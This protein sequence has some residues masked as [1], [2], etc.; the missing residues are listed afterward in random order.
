MKKILLAFGLITGIAG[1][2]QVY[3]TVAIFNGTI[4]DIDVFYGELFIVGD[5]S[6]YYGWGTTATQKVARYSNGVL[7]THPSFFSNSSFTCL[8]EY[9]G[10]LYAGGDFSVSG[11]Y[12]AL[13]WNG[14]GGWTA[15]DAEYI[16]LNCMQTYNGKL[17]AGEISSGYI[18]EKDGAGAFDSIFAVEHNNSWQ[19]L[20]GMGIYDGDLVMVGKFNTSSAGGASNYI[21]GY[22]GTNFFDYGSGLN[23]EAL[24]V[25]EYHGNMYVGGR[26]TN[27]S[28]ANAIG[29]AIWDGSTWSDVDGS[30]S[31]TGEIHDM[32]VYNNKLWVCGNFEQIGGQWAYDLAY[33]DTQ[34]WH[35]VSFP[36][37]HGTAKNLTVYNDKFYISAD[38][39]VDSSFLYSYSEP[40]GFDELEQLQL[41]VYPNPAQDEL[42]IETAIG[43]TAVEVYDQAGRLVL[44]STNGKKQLNVSSL[45][46]GVYFLH[47]MTNEG[48]VKRKF[49]KR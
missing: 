10:E 2:A 27:A 42:N 17:Y 47:C 15:E 13:K 20:H 18:Y 31:G 39:G 22:D 24:C 14:N 19:T 35:N 49:V 11:S 44:Q 40:V 6:Q 5:F 38:N 34:G 25:A 7:T 36:S 43:L 9:N 23:N 33:W 45:D 26:F 16:I 46:A 48:E 41:T 30:I 4:K 1:N 21:K 28:G 12:G 29:V 32:V 37:S 3:D 8:E